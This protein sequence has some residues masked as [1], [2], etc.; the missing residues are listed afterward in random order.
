MTD[1]FFPSRF[2]NG[3]Q[4]CWSKDQQLLAKDEVIRAKDAVIAAKDDA[5]AHKEIALKAERELNEKLQ[6]QIKL[7]KSHATPIMSKKSST[8]NLKSSSCRA[9]EEKDAL[10]IYIRNVTD[11][12]SLEMLR[13]AFSEFGTIR[14]LNACAFV[15]FTTAEAYQRALAVSSVSVGDGQGTVLTEKRVRRPQ[16]SFARRASRDNLKS[17]ASTGLAVESTVD[18]GTGTHVMKSS[19][20]HNRLYINSSNSSSTSVSSMD[21]ANMV[22]TLSRGSAVG[23]DNN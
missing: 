7:A 10:T 5:I 4:L 12:I 14:T 23:E 13:N 11:Q 15:E 20:V 3:C 1:T 9:Q 6:K 8:N 22:K 2:D 19:V 17:T 18:T 16:Q 21:S